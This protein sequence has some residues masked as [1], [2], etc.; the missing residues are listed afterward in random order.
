MSTTQTKPAPAGCT[1]DLTIPSATHDGSL[2]APGRYVLLVP[3]RRWEHLPATC[4]V[5]DTQGG[6]WIGTGETEILVCVGC[7]LNVT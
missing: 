1:W 4:P 3:G 6:E 7:G 2:N 5:P